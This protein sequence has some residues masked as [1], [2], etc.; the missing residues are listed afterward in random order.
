LCDTENL[1]D[2]LEFFKTTFR[3]N[4]YSIKQIRWA[5][6]PAVRNSKPKDKL[7]SVTFLPYIQTTYGRFSRMLAK[8]NIKCDSL[9]PRKISSFL[10]PVKTWN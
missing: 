9:L 4:S 3:E 2:E 6:N 1:H 10:C 8:H 7:T 5:L